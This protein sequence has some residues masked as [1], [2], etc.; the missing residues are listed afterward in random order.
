MTGVAAVFRTSRWRVV[1]PVMALGEYVVDTLPQ[2]PA[3]TEPGPLTARAIAGALCGASVARDAGGNVPLCAATGTAA[4][5]GTAYLGLAFRT[6]SV[7]RLPSV[8]AAVLEDAAA[9]TIAAAA[10]RGRTRR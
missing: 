10:V 1:L 6:W 7:G 5:L 3:R 8:V 9:V 2:T 4:A